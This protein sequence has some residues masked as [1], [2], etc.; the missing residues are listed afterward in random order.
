MGGGPDAK[1]RLDVRWAVFACTLITDP[2]TGDRYAPHIL[3]L[4]GPLSREEA[5]RI[6]TDLHRAV[7]ES[8]LLRPDYVTM[9]Y[10]VMPVP[11]EGTESGETRKKEE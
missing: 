3:H 1:R 10:F 8:R 4:T 2:H 7:M 6:S 5:S 9:R 11:S